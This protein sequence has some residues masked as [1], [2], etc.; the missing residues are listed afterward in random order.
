MNVTLKGKRHEFSDKD[1]NG[2]H[3]H[4]LRSSLRL[5]LIRQTRKGKPVGW[6]LKAMREDANAYGGWTSI[7]ST[8]SKWLSGF[9]KR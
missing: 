6:L 5:T 4:Y 1:I 7:K 2:H 9:N 3:H 8:E